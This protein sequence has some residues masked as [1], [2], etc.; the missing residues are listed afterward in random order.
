MKVNG[1][2]ACNAKSSMHLSTFSTL[3]CICE[4]GLVLP[5]AALPCHVA[6]AAQHAD[7]S[8]RVSMQDGADL[9]S[10][11]RLGY[12]SAPPDQTVA[13]LILRSVIVADLMELHR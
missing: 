3:Q 13:R 6:C 8:A 5:S 11:Q 10:Q 12:G 4:N 7:H 1:S 9:S 2:E